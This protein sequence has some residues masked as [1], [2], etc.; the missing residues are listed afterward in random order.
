MCL[1]Y[2]FYNKPWC[3]CKMGYVEGRVLLKLRQTPVSSFLLC[4]HPVLVA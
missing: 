4:S 3:I 2:E 1:Y